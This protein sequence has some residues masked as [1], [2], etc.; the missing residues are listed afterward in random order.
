MYKLAVML[1]FEEIF[2]YL[3]KS[4]TSFLIISFIYLIICE[5]SLNMMPTI[6]AVVAVLA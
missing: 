5:I 4:I 6:S 3:L 2:I 1:S